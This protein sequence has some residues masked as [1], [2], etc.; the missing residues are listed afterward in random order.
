MNNL[1]E[2]PLESF[3]EVIKIEEIPKTIKTK[4][5]V[6]ISV[7]GDTENINWIKI[8]KPSNTITLN[9]IKPLLITQ[10]KMFGMCNEMTYHYKVKTSD[11]GKV[12]Y[13]LIDEDNDSILPLFGDK[14][15]LQCWSK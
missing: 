11:G 9:D 12:G 15:E 13:E 7:N 3:Q 4:T 10:P 14:I 5:K 6:E 1:S 2:N 8:A